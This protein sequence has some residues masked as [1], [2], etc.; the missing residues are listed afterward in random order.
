MS[1]NWQ[2]DDWP[3]WTYDSTALIP[4]EQ[5]FLKGAGGGIALLRHLD[6]DDRVQFIAEILS[7]EGEKSSEIEGEVLDRE[8]LQSSIKRHFG[9]SV[10]SKRSGPKEQGMAQLMWAAYETFEA[11]LTHQM[12]HDWHQML[13]PHMARGYRS[14]AEPMQIVS[15]RSH[16]LRVYFEAPPSSQIQDEM[17]RFIA[18]FNSPPKN[19]TILGQAALL[20]VY[21]ESIHPFEDGNGRIG[22][23]LVEKYLSQAFGQPLL[24]ATSQI[25]RKRRKEYYERLGEC[26]RTL[27]ITGWVQFF[28][29]VLL[30]A[31]EESKRL[32]DFLMGKARLLSRLAGQLNTRQEKALL[33][34]FAEG[35]DGFAGGLSAD[36]YL[37]ITK[38]SRATATRDLA[39]LVEKGALT[40]TGQLRHTRYWLAAQ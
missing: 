39:D 19:S 40:K 4:L 38:T 28:A 16:D 2:L 20:H 13:C 36:N 5:A 1:W 27:E 34:M 17:E 31:Q 14:H 21:F 8:S 3:S 7:L 37:S 24:I 15:N 30:E 12:L 9:L 10:D 32:V 23:A 35:P 26:N 18:T 6:Q 25:I 29:G 22:R 33:R 11:P